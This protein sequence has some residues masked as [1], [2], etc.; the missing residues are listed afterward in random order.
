VKETKGFTL[1]ELLVVI[2]VLGL[3]AS[4][5]LISLDSARV[6][7][8][9]A[10]R[11]SDIS[12]VMKALELYFDANN[13]YPSCQM[14]CGQ[15]WTLGPQ[16]TE[17]TIANLASYLSPYI[18]QMPTDPKGP[19]NYLYVWRNNGSGDAYGLLVP[20]ANDGGTSCKFMS[21]GGNANWFSSAPL[22]NY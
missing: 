4:V 9:N 19:T 2:A 12:Q 6:K 10:K 22:C 1:I 16:N 14:A 17:R 13:N 3:L 11:K 5:V 20:F 7:A 18:S 8:R 21:T 15:A